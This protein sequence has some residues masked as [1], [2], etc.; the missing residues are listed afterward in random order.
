MNNE[1]ILILPNKTP[2]EVSYNNL[3]ISD[4]GTFVAFLKANGIKGW[5]TTN[6][7]DP[8]NRHSGFLKFWENGVIG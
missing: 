7:D 2:A 4:K 3:L 6:W 8:K 5:P 1:P